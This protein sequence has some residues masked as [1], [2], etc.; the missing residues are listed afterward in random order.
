VAE[1]AVAAEE[2][3]AIAEAVAAVV[4]AEAATNEDL[5]LPDS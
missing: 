3:A 5:P 2:T 4:V 1:A